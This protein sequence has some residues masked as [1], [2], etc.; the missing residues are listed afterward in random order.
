M[1]REALDALEAW[2]TTTRA[3][4]DATPWTAEW[5]R[6]RMVA[7]EQRAAYEALV[8]ATSEAPPSGA[9]GTDSETVDSA[10]VPP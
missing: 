10:G 4:R 8:G 6:L 5:V 7:Q 2:H 1:S 9:S 3:L